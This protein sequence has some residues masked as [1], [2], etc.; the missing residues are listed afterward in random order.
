MSTNP[1]FIN[2]TAERFTEVCAQRA[3]KLIGQ[4]PNGMTYIALQNAMV[5]NGVDDAIVG[6]HYVNG[7]RQT[8]VESTISG[9][10]VYITDHG[11]LCTFKK[12]D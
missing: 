8:T 7:V 2:I 1:N 5:D 3:S 12:E 9:L 4:A 11:H 10:G 6:I